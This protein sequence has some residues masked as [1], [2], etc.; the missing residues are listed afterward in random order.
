MH[1]YQDIAPSPSVLPT[2]TVV[3]GLIR[4]VHVRESF[5]REDGL[6]LDPSKLRPVARLGSVT[7]A[8]VVEGFDLP[9]VSWKATKG[10]YEEIERRERAA[11]GS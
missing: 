11:G 1:S 5:L 6:T 9:R 10:V 3:L 4:R 2:T 7:Y 8:R